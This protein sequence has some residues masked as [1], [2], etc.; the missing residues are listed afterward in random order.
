MLVASPI[1]QILDLA[2][3]AP[4]GDN[5]QPWAFEQ[6]DD[7]RFVIHGR[8]TRS[9]TV[10]DLDGRASQLSLGALIETLA[11]AATGHGLLLKVTRRADMPDDRPTFNAELLQAPGTTPSP[12][13]ESIPRRSVQRC[14]L[15]TTALTEGELQSLRE[16]VG[17]EYEL[18]VYQTWAERRRWAAMLWLNAGLRLRLPEAFEVHRRVI[19]WDARYSADRIPDQALG[20]AAPT[21]ALM[22]MAMTSWQR[23]DFLNSWLGGTIAPRIEM[24]L[25]PALA[26]AAH[27]AILAR[28]APETI[29]DHV[30]GGRAV[31]RFW[32]N[33]TRLGLQ[34]QPSL[35]PLVFARFLREGRDFTAHAPSLATARRVASLLDD[36]LSGQSARGVWL[37]R[38]GHGHAALARSGRKPLRALM[39]DAPQPVARRPPAN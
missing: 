2:R 38:I 13:R 17:S 22:R 1:Y 4:S 15:K 29:D 24:D 34:H 12:L 21:I 11:I 35:T 26:C 6:I 23:I 7:Q 19:Q 10:Y 31:Q 36:L 30:A 18:V 37:G 27:V 14:P 9:D 5:T 8:D 20:V 32:L 33:A 3:W 28:R 39:A 16:S 25:L